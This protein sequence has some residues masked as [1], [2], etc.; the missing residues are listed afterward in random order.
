[1]G[2]NDVGKVMKHDLGKVRRCA[3][4]YDLCITT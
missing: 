2:K 1:V 4:L 3:G